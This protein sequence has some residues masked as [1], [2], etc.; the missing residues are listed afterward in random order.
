VSGWYGE[1]LGDNQA[2]TSRKERQ[3]QIV[4]P[5]LDLVARLEE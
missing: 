1:R 5:T 2:T 3:A 4:T